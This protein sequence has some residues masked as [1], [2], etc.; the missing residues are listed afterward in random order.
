M[1]S[2]RFFGQKNRPHAAGQIMMV[3]AVSLVV[4]IGCA[5]IATDLGLMWTFK[6]QMQQAA[7]AAAIAGDREI[8]SG[9]GSTTNLTNVQNAAL[10]DVT[11]NGFT[12]A[13]LW[14]QNQ[15]PCT[16]SS[17]ETCVVVNVPPQS[18]SYANDNSAVE[19]IVSRPEPTF[20]LKIF[21]ISSVT[22]AA[23]AVAR[24]SAAQGCLY[25]LNTTAANALV[26]S[27]GSL[28]ST[29]CNIYVDS[30][31]TK[32]L[33]SSGGSAIT[34][35]NST[36]NVVASAYSGSGFSPTPITNAS[37]VSDPFASMPAPIF[38]NTCACTNF[39]VTKNQA[40]CNGN[41]ISADGTSATLKPGVYCG[42]ITVS[43]NGVS[44]NFNSGTYILLGGGLQVKG[45]ANASGSG[46]MFY[47][48][49]NA[50]YSYNPIVVSAS[51][52]T[53]SAPTSG[54]YEGILFFQDRNIPA[55][56]KGPSGPQN[57]VSGSSSTTFTGALYF[58]NTPLVYS[59]GSADNDCTE[60]I[61]D[62]LTISGSS[63]V[64]N[65]CSLFGS[66]GPPVKTPVVAE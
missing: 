9:N 46:V 65:G 32:G 44:A 66:F 6:R 28:F 60:L 27:G 29:Q 39:T 11:Q 34:A 37:P 21:N 1:T 26:V 55:N 40:A 36:I 17:G 15:N 53:L 2:G 56:D 58:P 3:V 42:G 62:T 38:S 51:S 57:T 10:A 48:T 7:D 25:A 18:G 30:N 59:G 52:T 47:N 14:T 64:N 12:N 24:Y 13:Q 5:A 41:T 61:A 20:F 16:G 31:N 33:V 43:G 23:R 35:T 22:V 8:Y 63:Y 4:L 50:T 19:V 49:Y 45:G 54:I